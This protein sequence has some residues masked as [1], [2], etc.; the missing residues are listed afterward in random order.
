MISA[1]DIPK[2][3]ALILCFLFLFFVSASIS[4]DFHTRGEGREAL[5][6]QDMLKTGNL[7]LPE[8]YG[9]V[10]PSKPPL[11][12]WIATTLSIPQGY[13]SELT[14]RLPSV[15]AASLIGLISLLM[16]APES[17]KAVAYLSVLI[18]ATSIEWLRAASAARVDM[19]LT[20]TLLTAFYALYRWSACSYRGYPWLLM[21]SM[22][23]AIL[24]KGPVGIVIPA[25]IYLAVALSDEVSP[26]KILRHAATVFAPALLLALSWYLAAYF[27][28]TDQFLEK[29]YFENIERFLSIKERSPHKA[30]A[31]S[32]YGT[33]FLGFMPWTILLFCIAIN[34]FR[35][36]VI[37][38]SRPNLFSVKLWWRTLSK[39]DRFSLIVVL[40]T[41]V[42]YSIPAGKRSV[43]ILPIYPFIAFW[44]ARIFIEEARNRTSNLFFRAAVATSCTAIILVLSVGT[45]IF[46]PA[47]LLIQRI[48]AKFSSQVIESQISLRSYFESSNL[49]L[50]AAFLATFFLLALAGH[51]IFKA[52]KEQGLPW[53]LAIL[54]SLFVY[55][56]LLVLPAAVNPISPK[57]FAKQI[58]AVVPEQTELFSYDEEFY[59]L[60]FYSGRRIYRTEVRGFLPGTALIVAEQDLDQLKMELPLNLSLQFL[61][62][63]EG[64]VMSYGKRLVVYK[65]LG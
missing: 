19:L 11:F 52:Q 45:F 2:S 33:V 29:V 65:I 20:A 15:L 53:F 38:F 51:I 58:S 14:S 13:I 57:V 5:V 32:L 27:I 39:I 17:S 41:L 12:H 35:R 48:P 4:R 40:I 25:L 62:R 9:G 21:L 3:P 49:L 64:S 56:Q 47:S 24:C 23:T 61:L 28:K 54:L 8:G 60:S 63:S 55:V 16:F 7:I 22:A 42:F 44:M 37:K 1:T 43:Y 10:V 46:A 26:G 30:L 34:K 36:R 18:L 59:A 6:M 50:G 31:L